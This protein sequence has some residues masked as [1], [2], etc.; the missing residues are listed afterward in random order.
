M[1]R[2]IVLASG[3]PRRRELLA[4]LGLEFEVRLLPGI[5][6]S[7]PSGL[8][9]EEIAKT[10]SRKK[11]TAYRQSMATDE[12][13]ITADTIVCVDDRVLGKPKDE[14]DRQHTVAGLKMQFKALVARDLW[15]MSQYFAIVNEENH[16]VRKAL[17][18]LGAE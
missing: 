7:Y 8:S 2:H 4:G 5:D 12:I 17:Q 11:A 6:E 15:D 1:V 3:S 9:G 14:A 16:I 13:I 10:I 18:E